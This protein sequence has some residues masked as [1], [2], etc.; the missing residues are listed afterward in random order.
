MTSSTDSSKIKQKVFPAQVVKILSGTRLA[1]NRG[2][3]H[4]VRPNQRVLVYCLSSEEIIDPQTGESL[5][6][7]E[8]YKGTG[9]IIH[10]QEKMSI[11]ESDRTQKQL[12]KRIEKPSL[13]NSISLSYRL[14]EEIYDEE[15]LLEFENPE[16]GDMVKPI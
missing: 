12:V 5:G 10:I 15:Y 7:L 2:T 4:Q 6:F 9:K 14:G 8:I 16:I 11:I 3:E 13:L 1:I